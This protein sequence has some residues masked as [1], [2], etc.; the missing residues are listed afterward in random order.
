MR[1]C[2]ARAGAGRGV[3]PDAGFLLSAALEL[4]LGEVSWLLAL[5][6]LSSGPASPHLRVLHAALRAYEAQEAYSGTLRAAMERLTE[7]A[8]DAMDR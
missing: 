8:E 6:R 5:L 4:L 1:C 7:A 2:L 3:G